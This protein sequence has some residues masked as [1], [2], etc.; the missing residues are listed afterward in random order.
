MSWHE[1][2]I[3]VETDDINRIEALLRLTGAVAI[4]L[5]CKDGEEILEPYPGEVSLWSSILLTALFP[6]SISISLVESYL[7]VTIG[8]KG[9]IRLHKINEK[10]WKAAWERRPPTQRIGKRLMLA[11]ADAKIKKTSRVCTRLNLGLAFG[12]GEHPTTS[13][14][15][16]WLDA[17][18]SPDMQVLDYGCGSGILA[19]SSLRLG[20]HSAWAVDIEPQALVATRENAGLNKVQDKLWIGVPKNLPDLQADLVIANIIAGTLQNLSKLFGRLVKPRGH[21]V[22]SGI[23]SSQIPTI[24]KAYSHEFEP[25]NQQHKKGWALLWS[26]RRKESV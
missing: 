16:E 15:L 17:H 11:A 26:K 21:L 18:L 4:S 20:A 6:P 7:Q 3:I 13:L 14:C 1:L 2:Q 5:T 23:L 9:P 22:L 25:F 19:I 10:D 12:T 24:S 8:I